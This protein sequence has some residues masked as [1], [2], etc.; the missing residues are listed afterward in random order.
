MPPNKTPPNRPGAG[1]G[2]LKESFEK[3]REDV[4]NLSYLSQ[5]SMMYLMLEGSVY[6][7][8]LK[9]N[10]SLVVAQGLTKGSFAVSGDGSRIAWQDGASL[11][12]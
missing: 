1:S 10:E 8:D 7:I 5:N 2:V 9:S 11:Y 3:V 4:N 6:G 12:E